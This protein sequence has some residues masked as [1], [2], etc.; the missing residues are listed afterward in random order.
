[1]KHQ[2]MQKLIMNLP[3]TAVDMA[4]MPEEDMEKLTRQ[5]PT[6][7][8][9]QQK[10]T[11]VP[12]QQKLTAEPTQRKLTERLTQQKPTAVDTALMRQKPTAPTPLQNLLPNPNLPEKLEPHGKEQKNP[13]ADSS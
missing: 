5:K 4:N 2:H 6:E 11:A 3:H 1:M 12:T 10:L 13:Q 7:R 9:T 8:L